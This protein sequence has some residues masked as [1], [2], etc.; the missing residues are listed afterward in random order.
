MEVLSFPKYRLEDALLPCAGQCRLLLDVCQ[1]LKHTKE[2]RVAK[3][4]FE[5]DIGGRWQFADENN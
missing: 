2:L 4:N 5:M 1:L 3:R